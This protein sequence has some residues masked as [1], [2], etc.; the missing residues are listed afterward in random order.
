M[1]RLSHVESSNISDTTSAL[2]IELRYVISGNNNLSETGTV[3][4]S[5][6]NETPSLLH[7]EIQDASEIEVKG[8]GNEEVTTPVK[9]DTE[10]NASETDELVKEVDE[11]VKEVENEEVPLLRETQDAMQ[12]R[13]GQGASSVLEEEV[14]ED[15]APTIET[16]NEKVSSPLV[17]NL[18]KTERINLRKDGEEA[19]APLGM[20]HEKHKEGEVVSQTQDVPTKNVQV[21]LEPV[22]NVAIED[23]SQDITTLQNESLPLS[24]E[25]DQGVVSTE[26]DEDIDAETTL[27][28]LRDEEPKM[29][30]GMTRSDEEHNHSDNSM[31]PSVDEELESDSDELPEMNFV[32]VDLEASDELPDTR[33]KEIKV[34]NRPPP[35]INAPENLRGIGQD[36]GNSKLIGVEKDGAGTKGS[37]KENEHELHKVRPLTKETKRE[38]LAMLNQ[39]EDAFESYEVIDALI[40]HVV[41]AV[42]KLLLKR[43][44][45]LFTKVTFSRK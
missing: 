26:S 31:I 35:N 2:D 21:E 39:F 34:V 28:L 13:A 37:N 45:G 11:L 23:D 24:E 38:F 25:G 9:E 20:R 17:K 43:V 18:S 32:E 12:F 1:Y 16:D 30:L 14:T 5:V 7:E 44:L 22:P 36:Y 6:V 29:K 40:G 4:E 42:P 27:N 41:C 33:S 15:N 10:A 8:M 3:K 19:Q